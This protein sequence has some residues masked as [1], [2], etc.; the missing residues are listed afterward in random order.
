MRRGRFLATAAAGVALPVRVSAA[1]AASAHV[2]KLAPV[3]VGAD[4]VIRTTVCLRPYRAHGFVLRRDSVGSK[5]VVH[6]YGHGGGGVSLSWGVAELAADLA[7]DPA[8]RNAAVVGAGAIGLA[9]ARVLQDRGF[10]VAIYAQAPPLETTSSRAGAQWSPVSTIDFSNRTPEYNQR[11]ARASAL[12][13]R[14]F[15]DLIGD[16]YGVRWIEN[17]SID[18][19]PNDTPLTHMRDAGLG[20][21]YPEAHVFGP[22]EHPFLGKYATRFSTMLIAPPVY[23]SAVFKDFLLRGGTFAIRSFRGLTEFAALDEAI[24]FNCTGLGAKDLLGDDDLVPVK[25]QLTVLLPQ[26]EVDYIVLTPDLYM[27]PRAD[28]IVLGGTHERGVW[29]LDVN[30]PAQTRILQAQQQFFAAMR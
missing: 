30:E 28:G 4:R 1:D 16:A 8:G 7:G 2:R 12:A 22:D 9:T 17:Y 25:G 27:F 19:D 20:A 3:Q 6:S 15:Q 18:D 24:V 14:A 11:L 21:L 29:S 13:Y 26:P 10:R 5:P 23:L